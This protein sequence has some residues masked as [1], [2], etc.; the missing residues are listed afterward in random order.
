MLGRASLTLGVAA[1]VAIAA[2]P[3]AAQDLCI[4]EATGVPFTG[5][6]PPD[7]WTAP[8][9]VPMDDPGWVGATQ[10]GHGLAAETA[11]LR[12]IKEGSTD[13]FLAF[14][15]PF[16]LDASHLA[17]LWLG[18][19][20]GTDTKV[21]V[22]S[23]SHAEPA[24]REGV[25]I[26]C[27]TATS[28]A[29]AH[30]TASMSF[31][32][33]IYAAASGTNPTFSDTETTATVWPNDF[34]RVWETTEGTSIY[35]RVPL[36]S[37]GVSTAGGSVS[38]WYQL[39]IRDVG[40]SNVA[41][42]AR[43]PASAAAA[44]INIGFN[45]ITQPTVGEWGTL[46]LGTGDPGC[47]AGVFIDRANVGVAHGAATGTL[48]N[49]IVG[50]EGGS[51]VANHF[52]AVPQHS[53]GGAIP[54]GIEARFR[55]ADWGSHPPSAPGAWGSIH[56]RINAA[57]GAASEWVPLV[58]G[59]FAQGPWTLTAAQRCDYNIG[60]PADACGAAT[61]DDHQCILTELRASGGAG[62]ILVDSVYKNTNF[63][64]LSDFA[65]VATIGAQGL[66][67]RPGESDLEY[68]LY[69]DRR[70]MPESYADA[71]NPRSEIEDRLRAIAADIERRY[72]PPAALIKRLETLIARGDQRAAAEL[73][74][75][76]EEARGKMPAPTRARLESIQKALA[77]GEVL[78]AV[79][80]LDSEVIERVMP[81]AIV[82]V[83]HDS[84]R[85]IERE[86]AKRRLFEPQGA[87]G[88]Y[89]RHDGDAYGWSAVLDGLEPI[90]PGSDWYRLRVPA[91]GERKI[92]MRA[93]VREGEKEPGLEGDPA[94]KPEKP[95]SGTAPRPEPDDNN[96]GCCKCQITSTA[97]AATHGLVLL[98]TL[99]LGGAACRRRRRR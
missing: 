43:Y 68:L 86:D 66:S 80:A 39:N 26:P 25:A 83:F 71:T 78:E 8:P 67:A 90:S 98:M 46:R 42:I 4:P 5:G 75:L 21:V 50:V 77:S 10:T 27:F 97:D 14:D 87:F 12:A 34:G 47:R 6:A 64:N 65:R 2:T 89:A 81:T 95:G 44:N 18:F 16:A 99:V 92:R 88:I 41:P 84:G 17:E 74:R 3:A 76:R 11:T 1:A 30:C 22:V 70:Q 56:D 73:A 7:W 72:S 32:Y 96:G 57:G 69:L 31:S 36:A 82:Y 40:G 35:M 55:I 51:P 63:V 48:T 19:D 58:G 52:V 53:A 85:D 13:L 9:E 23:L 49:R 37:L 93:R 94:W 24:G 59:T 38:F 28:P 45:F 29:P 62:D 33:R 91:G 20:D 60:L 61:H 15:T 54:A 79:A